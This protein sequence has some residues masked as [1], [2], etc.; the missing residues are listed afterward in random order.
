MRDRAWDVDGGGDA[1][2]DRVA[3]PD[4]AVTV[5]VCVFMDA[6]VYVCVF[7]CACVLRTGLCVRVFRLL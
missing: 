7:M 2:V 6:H 3:A 1:A 4:G 5:R